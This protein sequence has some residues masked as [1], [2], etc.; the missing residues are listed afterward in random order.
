MAWEIFGQTNNKVGVV[1]SGNIGP[2]IALYFSKVLHGHGV[3]VIV[4]DIAK[5]ALKS[6]KA[7]VNGKIGRGVRSGAFKKDEAESMVANISWTTEYSQLKGADLVIEAATED[8]AIKGKIFSEL[9]KME[10]HCS[11]GIRHNN[12]G[13]FPGSGHEAP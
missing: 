10:S 13:L 2:D 12:C 9:E 11:R 3:P 6:G 1:G 7:R 4:V 5:A 8:K